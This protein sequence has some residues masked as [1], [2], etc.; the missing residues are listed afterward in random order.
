MPTDPFQSFLDRDI[1]RARVKR[2]FDEVVGPY[3]DETINFG[4]RALKRCSVMTADLVN[5]CVP[6]IVLHRSVLEHTDAVRSLLKE[7]CIRPAFLQIRASIEAWLGLE[8]LLE[9]EAAFED[10]ARAFLVHTWRYGIWI[11]KQRDPSTVPG[12]KNYDVWAG[13]LDLAEW[14][15]SEE[16]LEGVRRE[17]AAREKQL[18]GPEYLSVVQEYDRVNRSRSPAVSKW[19]TVFNGPT[20]LRELADTVGQLN[21]Y[22]WFYRDYSEIAHTLDVHAHLSVSDNLATIRP[23]RQADRAFFDAAA[24]AGWICIF[25]TLRR[26]KT[27]RPEERSTQSWLDDDV[28]PQARRLARLRHQQE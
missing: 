8:Y 11:R 7:G 27:R 13:E 14:D 17:I 18:E 20:N 24:M 22:D 28:L 3:L 16:I 26:L 4:L 19:Y 25:A 6:E 10:R 9:S 15:F 23:L 5:I 21:F 12:T 1:A 2:A